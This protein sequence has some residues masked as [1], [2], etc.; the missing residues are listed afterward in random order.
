MAEEI[1]SL[2]IK[3]DS[4]DVKA[5][6]KS[7]DDLALSGAKAEKST[8][9]LT[10]AS[11]GLG[12]AVRTIAG[13]FVAL[14][15][16][17]FISESIKLNQRY[18]ELGIS[19]NVVGRNVGITGAKMD[20]TARSIQQM[21]I[22]MLESRQV[23]LKLASSHIDLA[24][25][26]KLADLARNAAIVGQIN[27]SEALGRIVHGVR[28]G[29]SEVLK[30]IG[31][32]V[33]FEQSYMKLSKQLGKTSTDLTQ[34]EKMQARLNDVYKNAPALVGLYE[35]SMANAGKQFRSTERLIEDLKVNLGGLFDLTARTAVRL[36]TD[37]LKKASDKT[38]EFINNGAMKKWGDDVAMGFARAGDTL[39]ALIGI[40]QIGGAMAGKVVDQFK[41]MATFD[42]QKI[43]EI[44]SELND[45]FKE[46]IDNKSKLQDALAAEI[47]SRDMLGKGVTGYNNNLK[48]QIKDQNKLTA[49]LKEKNKEFNMELHLLK[50]HEEMYSKARSLTDEVATKQEIYNKKLGELNQLKP[51]LSV[52]IYNRALA[53]ARE[54]L[55]KTKKVTKTTTD[56]VSQLWTQA[57]RNI[58]STLATS[59][60]NFFDDGL[61]GM[62]KNVGIAVGRIMSEFA[63]LK[64]AQ[65]IGLDRMFG[66][67][68]SASGGG[69]GMNIASMGMNLAS[70]ARGGFGSTGMIGTGISALGRFAGSGSMAAFGA[71]FGGDA[72]AGVAAGVEAGLTGSMSASAASMG[73]SFAAVAGPAMVAFMATQGLKMLAG[74]KRMGGGFGRAM[75]AVGDIPIIGDLFPFIPMLNGLF[76]HGP[77]KFRQQS[78]QGTATGG[79][80]DGDITNVFRA[81]GGLLVGNKHKSVNEAFSLEMQ[82]MLDSTLNGFA[83]STRSFAKNLG[84]SADFV[85][86]FNK[87]FQIKSEKGKQLTDEAIQEMLRGIGNEFARGVLPIVDTLRKAGEDSM[88]T[89]GRLSNE[90]VTLSNASLIL[91]KSVSEA[92]EFIKSVSFENRTAF[93]DAAGG[94]DALNQKVSFFADNFLTEADR[95][96]PAAERLNESMDG[97]GLNAAMSKDQFRD[98]VQSF[99]QVNG[100]TAETL[101]AMLNLAPAFI[102]V[103][104]ASDSLAQSAFGDLSKSVE[105]ERNR[106]T[107]VYNDALKIQNDRIQTVSESI[108]KLSELSKAL[109]STLSTIRPLSLGEARGKIQSAIDT[110]RGGGS[111]AAGDIQEALSRLAD[112][113]TSSF[114]TMLE[115]QRSQAKSADLVSTLSGMTDAQ[116]TLEERSLS[117]LEAARDRLTIGFE[118]EISHLDS[119]LTNAQEQLGTLD[120]IK[121]LLEA[122]RDFASA[123][124]ANKTVNPISGNPNIK[125]AQILD[126]S[127]ANAAD[128]MAI[129]NAAIANN[130]SSAQIAASGAFTQTQ[131]DQFVRSNNL[132]SFDSGV[133]NVKKT[134][135][136]MIHKGENVINNQQSN[137]ILKSLNRLVEVVANGN[138]HAR[139]TADLLVRVTRDGESLLTTAA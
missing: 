98:L 57:G 134:G 77:M 123:I 38:N 45:L 97:L 19:M 8:K 46:E 106:L 73:A 108:G 107:T 131:I 80:F 95:F 36:Y 5:G 11:I 128:P 93:I 63:A 43:Y 7:L 113:D 138:V 14:K 15:L 58:Q 9:A 40:F 94:I 117:A 28:S 61:K 72:I 25:A 87:E 24:N 124:S 76:G 88:A 81:K 51:Y 121:G 89:L 127:R 68:S 22:S 44:Q 53:K 47:I 74:D 30:T 133:R 69:G 17:Q 49:A 104:N 101:Q 120:A 78:M 6:A 129:Y 100:I 86:N 27:T 99:G 60:F 91:G 23:V 2:G 85:D 55:N 75:N 33:S 90:F 109:K 96:A 26:E 116:L 20:E 29:E 32:N 59:I 119:I 125:G 12:D 56:D 64:L 132:A 65:G 54:E 18:Q 118:N 4:R 136:A 1:V 102:Q 105:S 71:G 92:N 110:M 103:K 83:D 82:T 13:S 21:G 126:F 112:K 16:G 31:L 137:D 139:K 50:Q 114:S 67:G 10:L 52:D 135:L 122:Q 34:A 70:L 37:E 35:A 39:R 62:I 42:T 66:G 41:A 111:V 84:V 3:V 79:G 48:D 130:V 115:F